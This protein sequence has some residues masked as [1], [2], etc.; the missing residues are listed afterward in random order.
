MKPSRPSRKSSRP[1]SEVEPAEVEVE[2]EVEPAEAEA[3]ARSTPKL[4]HSKWIE[5][6]TDVAPDA[7][8]PETPAAADEAAAGEAA[9]DED[10]PP[11]PKTQSKPPKTT[12]LLPADDVGGGAA[13]SYRSRWSVTPT[14][15]RRRGETWKDRLHSRPGHPH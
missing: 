13:D 3:R 15:L 1:R 10:S 8:L 4:T 12:L 11:D 9:A 5:P 6:I 2:P 7:E 14:M